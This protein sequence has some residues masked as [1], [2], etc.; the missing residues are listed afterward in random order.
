LK[1]LYAKKKNKHNCIMAELLWHWNKDRD[2]SGA[3]G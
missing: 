3:R 1:R 2:Q